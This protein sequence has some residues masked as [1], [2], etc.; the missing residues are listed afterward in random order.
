MT[1]VNNWR[2]NHSGVQVNLVVGRKVEKPMSTV[3]GGAVTCATRIA[4]GPFKNE[5]DTKFYA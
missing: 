4:T 3:E 1:Y 5:S 2:G